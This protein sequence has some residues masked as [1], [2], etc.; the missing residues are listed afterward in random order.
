[1]KINEQNGQWTGE[2]NTSNQPHGE[3]QFIDD[4]DT[5]YKGICRNGHWDGYCN[6]N[7][8]SFDLLLNLV[9]SVSS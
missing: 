9:H 7:Y 3:G 2:A 6:D 8:L 1:M 4:F 5:K